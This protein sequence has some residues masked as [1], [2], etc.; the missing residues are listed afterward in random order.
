MFDKN[1]TVALSE[2]NI[3]ATINESKYTEVNIY[4]ERKIYTKRNIDTVT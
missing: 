3:A 1:E 4:T 2:R